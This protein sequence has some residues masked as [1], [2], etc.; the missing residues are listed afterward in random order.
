MNITGATLLIPANADATV[1]PTA[2]DVAD[3]LKALLP[4]VV[5]LVQLP[6]PNCLSYCPS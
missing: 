3:S 1:I 2:P 4:P 5:L 6:W